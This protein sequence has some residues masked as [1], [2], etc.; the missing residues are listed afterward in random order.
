MIKF[1]R[2]GAKRRKQSVDTV[3]SQKRWLYNMLCGKLEY[4]HYVTCQSWGKIGITVSII[5]FV[6]II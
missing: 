2:A 1:E 6:Y 5:S 3:M 4:P